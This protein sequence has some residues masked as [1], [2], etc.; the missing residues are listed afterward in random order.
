MNLDQAV[1]KVK[2]TAVDVGTRG[3]MTFLVLKLPFL[4]NPILNK[5]AT[6]VVNKI[7]EIA[8]FHTEL[9]AYSIYVDDFT[10]DQADALKEAAWKNEEVQQ[11][12]T[13][14][15]KLKAEKEL[16]DRARELIKLRK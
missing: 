12:G 3:V 8:V 4:N 14:E 13:E 2:K 9:F 11:N 16:I 7:L 15:E 6:L 5:L 1:E 10:D